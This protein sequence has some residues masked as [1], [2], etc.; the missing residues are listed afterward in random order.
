MR[1]VWQGRWMVRRGSLSPEA[2]GVD[3]RLAPRVGKL[4]K[5]AGDGGHQHGVSHDT[6]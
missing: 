2:T 5:D 4:K 3:L 1:T 6:R